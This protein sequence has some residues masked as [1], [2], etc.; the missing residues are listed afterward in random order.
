MGCKP[1]YKNLKGWNQD[2]SQCKT[3]DELPLECKTYIQEIEKTTG[4][5]VKIISVGPRRDQTIIRSEIF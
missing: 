5:E 4:V 3:F 1:V 2:I